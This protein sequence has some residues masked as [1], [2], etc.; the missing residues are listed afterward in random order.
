MDNTPDCIFTRASFAQWNKDISD[1]LEILSLYLSLNS[2]LPSTSAVRQQNR[3]MR[4]P[5][6]PQT[7]HSR[8]KTALSRKGSKG[9]K[10]LKDSKSFKGLCFRNFS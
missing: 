9:S 1:D 10:D 6:V 2:H 7:G 8:K 5:Q 4:I 3:L